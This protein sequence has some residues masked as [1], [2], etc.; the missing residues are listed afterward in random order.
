MKFFKKRLSKRKLTK[1]LTETA[2]I[3][4]TVHQRD[5]NKPLPPSP[6]LISM[7]QQ[8]LTATM[9]AKDVEVTN[10]DSWLELKLPNDFSSSFDLPQ[11]QHHSEATS[12]NK[13][14]IN[15]GKSSNQESEIITE[16]SLLS[17]PDNHIDTTTHNSTSTPESV[18]M[19]VA[20]LEPSSKLTPDTINADNN[21]DV[22]PLQAVEKQ[23]DAFLN[24]TSH[25]A[26]VLANAT[27]IPTDNMQHIRL[28]ERDD[29]SEMER[30]VG[31]EAA[32]K[33]DVFLAAPTSAST[34]PSIEQDTGKVAVIER[35]DNTV[36]IE[37]SNSSI[38]TEQETLQIASPVEMRNI[39]N[40]NID[41]QL[42]AEFPSLAASSLPPVTIPLVATE[43]SSQAAASIESSPQDLQRDTF[44]IAKRKSAISLIPRKLHSV[45]LPDASV[46]KDG[47]R[48]SSSSFIPVLATRHQ[49]QNSTV[50]SMPSTD[51]LTTVPVTWSPSSSSERNSVSSDSASSCGSQ[52]LEKRTSLI[53]K[54]SATQQQL[55]QSKIPKASFGMPLTANTEISK[56]STAQQQH[57]SRLPTKRNSTL[58]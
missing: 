44:K 31:E 53:A 58:A 46:K 32:V 20:A 48:A 33:G 51:V 16:T 19:A 56:V 39:D 24:D 28:E 10:S 50:C 52:H 37:S 22:S 35:G 8:A 23:G 42:I 9:V 41:D 47:R 38:S 17:Y 57:V 3:A 27:L 29:L 25:D 49:H 14:E 7:P 13:L 54:S 34:L 40:E 36:K 18:G 15:T 11:L 43:P 1:S 12:S 6:S 4:P 2:L 30:S 45:N 26:I 21:R 5:N 55:Q